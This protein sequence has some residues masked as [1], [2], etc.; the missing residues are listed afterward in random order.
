MAKELSDLLR[1]TIER[2]LPEL[3][4]LGDEA[5]AIRPKGEGSWSP[6][7][8]LGHLIDSA[9]NNHMRFVRASLDGIYRGPGYAQN[10]WVSIHAYQEMPWSEIVS[11]WLSH[12]R[13]VVRTVENVPENRLGADCFIGGNETPETLAFIIRDYV[14]HMQHHIDHL[15]GREVVTEYPSQ[16]AAKARAHNL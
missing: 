5:A 2:E 10:D 6:K 15:L 13:L 9:A 1:T 11:T 16:A 7:E 4:R 12:N 8:E 14:L 3:E